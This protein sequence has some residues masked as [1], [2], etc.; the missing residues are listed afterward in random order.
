[1]DIR[2][3]PITKITQWMGMFSMEKEREQPYV[4]EGL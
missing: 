4:H 3:F 2:P 1:M